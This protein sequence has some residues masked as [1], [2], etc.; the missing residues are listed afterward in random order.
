MRAYEFL[1]EYVDPDEAKKE[2][3]KKINDI[4]LNDDEQVKLLDRVYTLSL[5]HI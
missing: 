4:D 2:I 3:L 5:I 1:R